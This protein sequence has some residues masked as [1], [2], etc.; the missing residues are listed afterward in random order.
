MKR[1]S[2]FTVIEILVVIVLTITSA[3]LVL[4]Q[5]NNA[6]ATMRDRERKI[7]INAMYFQ[8]TNVFYKQNNYYPEKISPE[9][10]NGVD[11]ALFTDPWGTF[12]GD[13]GSNYSYQAS[14]CEDSRCQSFKLSS[15]MEKEAGY[16]K[17][18]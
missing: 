15:F 11:P 10:L 4:V 8:L 14:N 3:I 2:G 13:V 7:A 12:M 6:E 5:K 17:Q 1:K 18:K 9:I 16:I